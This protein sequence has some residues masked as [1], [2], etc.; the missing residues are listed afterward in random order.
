MFQLLHG[1][2]YIEQFKEIPT[3]GKLRAFL[4]VVD[5][6]DKKS[7]ALVVANGKGKFKFK[8]NVINFNAFIY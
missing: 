3:S 7:G 8:F 1:E 5:I 4:K 6:L 2:Q